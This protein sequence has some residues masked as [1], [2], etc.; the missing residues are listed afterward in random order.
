MLPLGMSVSPPKRPILKAS[1]L[2][3]VPAVWPEPW[4]PGWPA[5]PCRGLQAVVEARPWCESSAVVG[6][7]DWGHLPGGCAPSGCL[8]G[9]KGAW[10]GPDAGQDAEPQGVGTPLCC[11]HGDFLPR[12]P[13]HSQGQLSPCTGMGFCVLWAEHFL[14]LLY[15]FHYSLYFYRLFLSRFF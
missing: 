12:C 14:I 2:G 1:G 11:L 15:I 10:L 3:M 4:F 7:M 5:A 8:E 13:Y 6:G 9:W